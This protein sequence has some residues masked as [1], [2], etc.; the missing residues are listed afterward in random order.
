MDTTNK[1]SSQ[2]YRSAEVIE[3]VLA[4]LGL[5]RDSVSTYIEYSLPNGS[6][7]RLRVSDHGIYLQNWYDSNKE[8]RKNSGKTPKM[9]IGQN[10]AI[11]FAP[12][13]IECEERGI[14]FPMKIKNVTTAKTEM[15]N[16]VKPQFSVRHICYFSWALSDNDINRISSELLK[17]VSEGTI[18][19]EPLKDANLL[20]EWKDISNLPP[21][22]II[23]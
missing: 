21:R 6:Y 8:K 14:P 7:I 22:R 2:G 19:S 23:G 11:T 15:G 13:S 18:Y 3:R 1:S 17:C 12:N 10:L 9:N 16:N 5:R 4:A 20:I